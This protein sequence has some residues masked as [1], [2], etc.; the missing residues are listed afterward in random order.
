MSNV[1]VSVSIYGILKEKIRFDACGGVRASRRRPVRG[2]LRRPCAPVGNALPSAAPA[3]SDLARQPRRLGPSPFLHRVDP[4]KP[5]A[6]AMQGIRSCGSTCPTSRLAAA[7]DRPPP[8][9]ASA[10][11]TVRVVVEFSRPYIDTHARFS[12]FPQRLKLMHAPAMQGIRS[13]GSTCPTSRLAAASDRSKFCITY[14]PYLV[15]IQIPRGSRCCRPLGCLRA[16][17]GTQGLAR[18]SDASR[19]A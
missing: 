10:G 14:H 9:R 13:C 8:A 3:R 16:H 6:P 11:G 17:R 12:T 5:S 18:A 15:K 4:S 7:S 1:F 2:N 19:L